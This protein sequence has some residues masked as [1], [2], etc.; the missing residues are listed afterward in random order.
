[1]KIDLQ[2][3]SVYSS[4]ALYKDNFANH[5]FLLD[6]TMEIEKIFKVSQKVGLG[7]ISIT[8]HGET[9]AIDYINEKK[10]NNIINIR[11]IEVKT[12]LGEILIYGDVKKINLKE[13]DYFKIVKQA[14]EV[15]CLII[16]PH[17]FLENPFGYNGLFCK[18]NLEHQEKLIEAVSYANAIEVYYLR[19]GIEQ[20]LIRLA[21]KHNLTPIATSDAHYYSQ[22]GKVYTEI[23]NASSEEEVLESLKKGKIL[24]L[25]GKPTMF[26]L[27]T[28]LNAFKGQTFDRFKKYEEFESL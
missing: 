7:A 26:E 15:G 1:M 9:Y 8:D 17:P 6:S 14:K 22:I 4:Q 11:G 19:T 20:K 18:K 16:I 12:N 3:H 24:D 10:I 5:Q 2:I 23:P 25:Y 28:L 27:K 21:K 13:S